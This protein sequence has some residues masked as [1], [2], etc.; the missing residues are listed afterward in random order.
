VGNRLAT[1]I[2]TG[3]Y[4]FSTRRDTVLG[5]NVT[6]SLVLTLSLSL[7]IAAVAKVMAVAVGVENGIGLP[8]LVVIS[9][10]GGTLATVPV[11]LATVGMA[12]GAV[13]YGW[14]VDNLSAPLVST[15]G[16]VLTLPALWAATALAGLAVVTPTLAAAM[17]I[18]GVVVLTLGWRADLDELRR[19]VRESLPVLVVACTL[20]ALAG[21][22][23]E[24]RVGSFDAFPALLVLLPAFLSSA[25]A[26]GGVLSARL[27]S[28]LHLGLALP[29]AMP[30]R[31][32]RREI[33]FVAVL[34]GPV[35]LFNGLG[36]ELVANF[37]GYDSPGLVDMLLV[38][39]LGAIVAVTFVLVVAYEGTVAAFRLGLDPDTYGI[40]IV[41]STVDFAG[42]FALVL[43]IAALGVGGG[44]V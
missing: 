5:Q 14:D 2:H 42:A 11:L 15:L 20:S 18:A 35:F 23:I 27:A 31:D 32:A 19:I 37:L 36:A 25:G 16:D 1:A 24:R 40:P 21:V 8:D 34:A 38:T 17:A 28:R 7:V 4:R 33:A 41:T 43:A 10:V 26:L 3:T 6:A 39:L 9:V 30:T 13:R 29:A 44:G 22:A 12:G